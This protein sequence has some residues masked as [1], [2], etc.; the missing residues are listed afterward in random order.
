MTLEVVHRS[1]QGS[2]AV[3]S[4]RGPAGE[5]HALRLPE[6]PSRELWFHEADGPALV[7]GSTQAEEVAD[8]SALAR[9]GAALVRRHSGGGAVL[10]EPGGLT[11]VDVVLPATDPLWERDVGRSFSWL[12]EAWVATLDALGIEAERHDGPLRRG[13]WGRLVCFAGLGPGEVVDR[14]GA[15][16][17]GL[18]Q[19]RTRDVAR[20][21]CALLHRWQPSV[22]A[23][24]LALGD[25]QR[26]RAARELAGVAAVVPFPP[27]D[28]AAALLAVLPGDASSTAP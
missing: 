19:R 7:L 3:T 16:L 14:G 20:F 13:E 5:F 21:Q 12:G 6:H 10:V 23:G 22:L 1:R 26:E 25:A 24:L 27:E 2:W 15:K 11:W 9:H 28:V 4:T 17:V 8:R 18:A